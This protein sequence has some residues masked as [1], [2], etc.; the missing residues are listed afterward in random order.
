MSP[1]QVVLARPTSVNN[2]L[3][4]TGAAFLN[5][6][7]TVNSGM[8]VASGNLTVNNNLFTLGVLQGAT[9]QAVG[10]LSVGNGG[11]FV[12]NGGI[13]IAGG[14]F[15]MTGGA[16]VANITNLNVNQNLTVNLQSHS[17]VASPT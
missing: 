1:T 14:N 7:A 6:G 3:T 13:Q 8:T 16:S 5:A 4:T 12:A 15:N 11:I 17:T 9:V 2:T 10:S